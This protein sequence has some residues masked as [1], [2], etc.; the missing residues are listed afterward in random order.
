[1]A[2]EGFLG[3]SGAA[4]CSSYRIIRCVG[5]DD[6]QNHRKL[7]VTAPLPSSQTAGE[8]EKLDTTEFEESGRTLSV[9]LAHDRYSDAPLDDRASVRSSDFK[10]SSSSSAIYS[11]PMSK[12]EEWDFKNIAKIEPVGNPWKLIE[13]DMIILVMGPTGTGKSTFIRTITKLWGYEHEAGKKQLTSV[14]EAVDAVRISFTDKTNTNLVLVDSPGL[15]DT[16]YSNREILDKIAKWLMI[17]SVA[18][19][20]GAIR[21]NSGF[22]ALNRSNASTALS[23]RKVSGILYFHRITDNRLSGSVKENFGIFKELCGEDFCQRVILVTTMWPNE[24]DLEDDPEEAQDC[25]DREKDLKKGFWTIV[26]AIVKIEN[27]SKERSRERLLIQKEIIEDIKPIPRTRAGKYLEGALEEVVRKR[28][29]E[30]KRLQMELQ[31]QNSV[32]SGLEAVQEPAEELERLKSEKKTSSVTSFQSVTSDD[33]IIAFMG[34][35]KSGKT[36]CIDL[37]TGRSGARARPSPGSVMQDLEA[38]RTEDNYGREVVLLDTPGFDDATRTGEEVLTLVGDWLQRSYRKDVKL[39]GL[40][41]LHR[42]TD[43]RIASTPYNS[44]R[45]FGKLCGDAAMNRVMLVTTMWQ[46]LPKTDQREGV[47]EDREKELKEKFWN[48]FIERGSQ[49]ERL[50]EATYDEAWRIV[51][52]LVD[53]SLE[54]VQSKAVLLQEVLVDNGIAWN[55]NRAGRELYT[56]SKNR[57]R[58]QKQQNDQLASQAEGSSDPR[59]EV[60]VE[61]DGLQKEI[62]KTSEEAKGLK[63]FPLQKIVR[64]FSPSKMR[65]KAV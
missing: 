26:N 65:A 41:Y 25:E 28:D 49:V 17:A 6:F 63:R 29:E 45:M 37:L 1:M 13:D 58:A 52:P 48:T 40:I 8:N 15:D 50:K 42:I 33:I 27:E 20:I 60:L 3:S 34:P 16:N 36:F 56:E 22:R 24:E 55:E 30:M 14:T 7:S 35:S 57:P 51:T 44:L 61:C 11:A 19:F 9:N 2:L 4:D 59:L 32:R 62:D 23:R 54:E 31:R 21:I 43:N 39:S 46:Q 12:Y 47:G 5:R 38:I 18:V 64:L 10:K 53:R